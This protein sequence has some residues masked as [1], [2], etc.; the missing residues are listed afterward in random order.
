[1][2]LLSSIPFLTPLFPLSILLLSLEFMK[3]RSYRLK[4]SAL[5][6]DVFQCVLSGERGQRERCLRVFSMAFFVDIKVL[7]MCMTGFLHAVLELPAPASER[8]SAPLG[9]NSSLKEPA[10][11]HE[12]PLW[13]GGREGEKL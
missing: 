5:G 6:P 9:E 10:G 12:I 13:P 1:M 7:V 11:R 4:S 2:I 3:F 8:K